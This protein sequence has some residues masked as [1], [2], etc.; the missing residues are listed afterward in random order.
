MKIAC[1]IRYQI[2]PFQRDGFEKHAENLTGAVPRGGGHL[3]GFFL[4]YE[5]TNGLGCPR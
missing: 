3:V 1:I 4:P 2:D 5:G